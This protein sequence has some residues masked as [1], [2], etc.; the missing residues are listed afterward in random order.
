M[1]LSE[2][3][4]QIEDRGLFLKISKNN[5]LTPLFPMKG[6]L[7]FTPKIDVKYF[8]FCTRFFFCRRA[9]FLVGSLKGSIG[10][11]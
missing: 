6:N 9:N 7:D 3:A 8:D 1:R 5:P 4:Y 2:A 10:K 11:S